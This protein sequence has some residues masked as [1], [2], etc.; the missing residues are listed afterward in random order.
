MQQVATDALGKSV[1]NIQAEC[2][3]TR[4]IVSEPKKTTTVFGEKSDMITRESF[5]HK[6]RLMASNNSTRTQTVYVFANK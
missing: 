5:G 3:Y 4:I 6:S 2:L 1:Y